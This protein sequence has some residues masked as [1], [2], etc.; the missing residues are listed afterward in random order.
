MR[1]VVQPVETKPGIVPGGVSD[2]VTHTL[3]VTLADGGGVADGALVVSR[4][5]TGRVTG[6][7]HFGGGWMIHAGPDSRWDGEV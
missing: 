3:H 2:G 5:M 1:A 6:K 4:A 7:E